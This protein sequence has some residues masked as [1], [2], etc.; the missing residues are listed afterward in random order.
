MCLYIN[1]L[2]SIL[3][4]KY[5]QDG[6]WWVEIHSPSV[7]SWA[8]FRQKKKLNIRKSSDFGVFQLPRV[9]RKN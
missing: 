5:H 2:S 8:K 9:R 4:E 3:H 1:N 6:C 7:F